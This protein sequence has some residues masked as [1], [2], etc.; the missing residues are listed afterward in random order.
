MLTVRYDGYAIVTEFDG[1]RF[2]KLGNK[3][4][5]LQLASNQIDIL[6]AEIQANEWRPCSETELEMLK[7]E[8]VAFRGIQTVQEDGKRIDALYETYVREQNQAQEAL[9]NERDLAIA[10][11]EAA[12]P[13]KPTGSAPSPV[14]NRS[15][16]DRYMQQVTAAAD[17]AGIRGRMTGQYAPR[18]SAL[19]AQAVNRISPER[20][21]HAD[22]LARAADEFASLVLSHKEKWDGIEPEAIAKRFD[23]H[24]GLH[25]VTIK[26]NFSN[27]T[28]IIDKDNNVTIGSSSIVFGSFSS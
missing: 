14:T 28:I 5:R 16:F 13:K 7:A 23:S 17:A 2:S 8:V 24:R 19:A 15:G 9:E 11:A 1:L 25:G 10:R 22:A 21:A 12:A 4:V 6:S 20:S 18:I 3:S 27:G 26:G